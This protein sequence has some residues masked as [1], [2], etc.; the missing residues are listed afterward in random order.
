MKIRFISI[1]S[2]LL[3][4]ALKSVL[5]SLIFLPLFIPDPAVSEN[6]FEEERTS[7]DL[8]AANS[9]DGEPFFL[10]GTDIDDLGPIETSYFFTTECY[11]TFRFLVGQTS[12]NNFQ[13]S[14][15]QLSIPPPV[16]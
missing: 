7:Y 12:S 11:N 4:F 13:I 10:S 1:R 2:K 16:I 9:D 8:L 6:A 3:K 5:I 14:F 15:N